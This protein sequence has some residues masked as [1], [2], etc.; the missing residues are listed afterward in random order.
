[1]PKIKDKSLNMSS[2]YI[3][4]R[5]KNNKA[6]QLC[7]LRKKIEQ[8][9]MNE[10]ILRLESENKILLLKDIELDKQIQIWTKKLFKLATY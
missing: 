6:S 10:E 8:K 1:M 2:K 4:M 3:E 9:K 7:R 5:K